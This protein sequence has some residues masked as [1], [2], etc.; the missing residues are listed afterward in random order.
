MSGIHMMMLGVNA[1]APV[2][3]TD[4]SISMNSTG[5]CGAGFVLKTD[6]TAYWERYT[7]STP[8]S[9]IATSGTYS[10]EWLVSG[11]SSS[12]EAT[13]ALVSGGSA[14]N[15]GNGTLTASAPTT[16]GSWVALTS[17][18]RWNLQGFR[19]GPGGI[20]GSWIVDISIRDGTTLA[21]LAT[22]RITIT[23]TTP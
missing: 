8:G 7:L 3:L 19:V 16:A 9:N 5:D 13:F 21:T 17:D 20:S 14:S 22:G 12:Y 1:N 23:V 6:G 11:S 4:H 10:G 2:A 18:R 15:P